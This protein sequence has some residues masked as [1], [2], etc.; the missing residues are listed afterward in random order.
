[1]A[2]NC[3]DGLYDGFSATDIFVKNKGTGYTYNDLIMLPGHINFGVD[4]VALKTQLTKKISLNTPIVSSPMD[5]VT[6]SNMAIHLALLG[7]MGIIHYNMP[8]EKQ[9]EEVQIVKRF[10]NGFVT[11]PLAMRPDNRIADIDEVKVK[12][13]FTGVPITDSG[14]MGG[15]LL[16]IVTNRDI[17]FIKDRNTLLKDVMTT[18]ADLVTAQE[19]CTLEEANQT[20]RESKKGK[21]PIVN[22]EGQLVALITR[23]DLKKNRDYPLASKDKNKQLLV[24]AAVGTR[25]SDKK[26]VELLYKAGVNVIVIDS[27]QGDSTYQ[28]DMI[29]HIK[30]NYPELQVIGGNIV[31]RM[32]AKHL[33][34]WGVDG[35]RVGM[36]VGSICTTQEVTA[37]GRGQAAS[38]Y[39]VSQ[40]AAQ[41]GVPV[42]ADGGIKS[43]GDITKALSLGASVV[44]MGSMLAGT[45][46]APG[47]YFYRDG[48]RLK[49]YRGMGSLEAMKVGSDVRYFNEGNT[50]KVAQGVSGNVK[51]KGSVKQFVPY[52]MQGVR[53]GFQDLGVK[54]LT[55]LHVG[56]KQGSVRYELRTPA[57]QAEGGVHSLYSYE[58]TGI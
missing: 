4:D 7:G 56:V 34:E 52:L 3:E 27:S 38:V 19:G 13:G 18:T 8:A 51:D 36:G 39:N 21:L 29:H 30:S 43:I 53:H 58:K 40:Y 50:I 24:G 26:R 47:E 6:E 9:V 33:I 57:S 54:S 11:Q 5:T 55:E 20:L 37:V 14:K 48:V 32:Q 44:M 15:K 10:E 46:E 28:R 2:A 17:D 45:E 49:K 41:F 35:L 25:E 31:T 23:N 16:G 1:M 12:Y 22:K 42:V